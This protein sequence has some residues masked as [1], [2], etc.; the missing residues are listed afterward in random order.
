MLLEKNI[1]KNKK[2]AIISN[3]SS[4]LKYDIDFNRYDIA[5]GI[6]R[7]YQTPLFEKINVLYNG[8]GIKDWHNVE[9][10]IK[11]ISNK[12]NFDFFIACPWYLKYYKKIIFYQLIHKYG[13]S[14]NFIYS[15]NILRNLTNI[16]GHCGPMKKRPLSGVA[17]LNHILQHDP[18]SIDI[19]GY[20]FYETES[21]YNLTQYSSMTTKNHDL[22]ENKNFLEKLI[23]ENSDK[24]NRY[25]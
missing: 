1:Y 16:A 6:N 8:L 14:H 4:V 22:I 24:I 25:M 19:Y 12:K 18:L 10:M 3:G 5:V 21:V 11:K 7:I 17:V 20:D 9:T 15:N 13:L 2:I 23:I